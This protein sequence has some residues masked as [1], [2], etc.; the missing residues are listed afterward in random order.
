MILYL[1][2]MDSEAKDIIDS[3]SL[4]QEKPFKLYKKNNTLL[5]ITGIGKTNASFVASS[6]LSTNKVSKVINLGFVGAYGDFKIGDLV[7]VKE[8]L[9]HDF[10]LQ[11]FNY[12]LG[13]VPGLPT[14]YQSNNNDL[15]KFSDLKSSVLYTGDY[16]MTKKIIINAIADMEATAIFQVGYRLNI[17]VLSLKVVSDVIGVE[18]HIDDYNEFEQNGS[19]KVKE[20]FERC[21]FLYG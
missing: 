3:F 4:I 20:L 21:E 2:A 13:Q 10:D 18:S 11:L 5:A 1:I 19:S 6:L 7:V 8:A 12:E 16:F 15:L 17:D 14:K 9:Y